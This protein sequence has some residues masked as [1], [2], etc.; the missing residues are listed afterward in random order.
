MAGYDDG[1]I[2]KIARRVLLTRQH[3][4]QIF[5]S[6]E[7]KP[8]LSAE[9]MAMQ[10]ELF[11]TPCYNGIEQALK[12]VL[13]SQGISADELRQ[14]YG[15]DLVKLFR[16]LSQEARDHV[17]LHFQE[18]RSLHNYDSGDVSTQTAEQ[19]ISH[20][21]SGDDQVGSLEWRYFQL[22]GT[23]GL[24]PVYI[25]SMHE[26]W[27]ALCCW[28]RNSV[29]EGNGCSRLSCRLE[30][31]F[32][33]LFTRTAV[34][35][36]SVDELNAWIRHK[37]RSPL[38]AV[39]DL[40]VKADRAL[41]DAVEAP[42]AL[43]AMLGE[44]ADA[45]LEQMEKQPEDPDERALFSRIRTGEGILEWSQE[46]GAFNQLLQ[47]EPEI[48]TIEEGANGVRIRVDDICVDDV[49]RI[50]GLGKMGWL[51]E[52][53]SD[54]ERGSARSVQTGL[55]ECE[56]VWPEDHEDLQHDG[57]TFLPHLGSAW[58]RVT[59]VDAVAKPHSR[60]KERWIEAQG[61]RKT[62]LKIRLRD[63]QEVLD[64]SLYA[65]NG[66]MSGADPALYESG[67]LFCFTPEKFLVEEELVAL[68]RMGL[69]YNTWAS[70]G[71]GPGHWVSDEGSAP[72]PSTHEYWTTILLPQAVTPAQAKDLVHEI[73]DSG[74]LGS[75]QSYYREPVLKFFNRKGDCWEV[76]QEE[77]DQDAWSFEPRKIGII[78]TRRNTDPPPSLQ[79]STII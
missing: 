40:L 28:I 26:V 37:D 51:V 7:P 32:L 76:T 50:P 65:H 16:D 33:R 9:Y 67:R 18:H 73:L 55:A 45:A 11:V 74:L 5:I 49:I 52:T 62:N 15:H 27:S 64:A 19:F 10:M 39:V 30:H 60:L 66:F 53:G 77:A 47:T 36:W 35:D 41:L 78:H 46:A 59:G 6:N 14:K 31:K 58:W 3:A 68:R 79:D 24:P 43:R 54:P 71:V 1:E 13:L 8:D 22:D 29:L 23:D 12:L 17:E 57:E 69:R 25:W 70:V 2:T 75:D 56:F 61:W 44:T 21:N 72:E 48:E 38:A 63:V 42:E 34:E 20:I 4:C